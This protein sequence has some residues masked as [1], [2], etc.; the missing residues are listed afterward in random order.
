[1]SPQRCVDVGAMPMQHPATESGA[2]GD[3]ASGAEGDVASGA[4]PVEP[5]PLG[6]YH[7]AV[8]DLLA[9]I[10]KRASVL[11]WV[12]S[13]LR[14]SRK[15]TIAAVRRNVGALRFV[16]SAFKEDVSVMS[17]ALSAWVRRRETRD[18]VL[19]AVPP[20]LWACKVFVMAA[21]RLD[22][23][24][25]GRASDELKS[26]QDA[27]LA[28][29]RSSS[30]DASKRAAV[31]KIVPL[32]LW[33]HEA[34]VTAA[35]RVDGLLLRFASATLKADAGVVRAA[36]LHSSG[37][38][39][40]ADRSFAANRDFVLAIAT[41]PNTAP[42]NTRLRGRPLQHAASALQDDEE[43]VLAAVRSCGAALEDASAALKANKGVV[44]LAVTQKGCALRHATP[45]LQAD[46][47][48]VTAAVASEGTALQ[49]ACCDLRESRDI[50]RVAVQKDGEAFRYTTSVLRADA[51][52]VFEM[53]ALSG[54]ALRHATYD[55]RDDRGVVLAAVT[56]DGRALKF[57]SP[58]LQEDEAIVL[59]AV[60][61]DGH[62][63]KF[64]HKTLRN[65]QAIVTAAVYSNG[66]ALQFASDALR[67]NKA[68]ALTAVRSKGWALR[69][70]H[71]DLVADKDVVLA[72]V[73]QDGWAIGYAAVHL[74]KDPDIAAAVAMRPAEK[75]AW[76]MLLSLT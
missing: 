38:L 50:V 56:Q 22:A 43:L 34:F 10:A 27:A 7:L 32:V 54:A 23:L 67:N 51:A 57:A 29:L 58:A 61:Q 68:V 20:G 53:C 21:V 46:A 62:A 33:T 9:A 19:E 41:T 76:M 35:V 24:L 31:L 16:H 26:D 37:A 69:F 74:H 60:T 15:F 49:Y 30:I 4:P 59:A 52:F 28:A 6:E 11:N 55:I 17:A 42:N 72:A 14:C 39:E 73:Q 44:L 8:N 47:E 66:T 70:V 40:F 5:V 71:H 63:L 18:A 13:T 36:M 12:S 65:T 64:A 2:E 1:M 48:V 45:A 25:L 3:V 75:P